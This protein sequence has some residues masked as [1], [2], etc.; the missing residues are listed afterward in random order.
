MRRVVWSDQALE[1]LEAITTYVRTDSPVAAARLEARIVEK[2]DSL[3]MMPDRGRP[4]SR[5]R[6][7]IAVTPTYLLCYGVAGEEVRIL[8]VRHSARRPET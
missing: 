1:Q 6:R 7:V 8:S 2:A 3:G 4:I 5:A